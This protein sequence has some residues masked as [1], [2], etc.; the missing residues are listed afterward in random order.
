MPIK[1]CP[2]PATLMTCAA[3]SQP[4]ALCAV[5]LS[6]LSMCRTCMDE[7]V[8][9]EM[10]GAALLAQIE[11]ETGTFGSPANLTRAPDAVEESREYDRTPSE[12][13][14]PLRAAVEHEIDASQWHSECDGVSSC[15]V[16]MSPE[17]QGELLLVKLAAGAEWPDRQYEGEEL[18]L[19]LR[20][21]CV[22]DGASL[23]RGDYAELYDGAAHVVS[24]SEKTGCI[25]LIAYERLPHQ[26]TRTIKASAA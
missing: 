3:G 5:V 9:M 15:R 26:L 19:V 25:L 17:A 10:I 2:D 14:S 16:P 1:H 11:P 22:R 4:E 12:I 8:R 23:E 21:T 6:H 7:V 13:P 20:G 18:L 24:A